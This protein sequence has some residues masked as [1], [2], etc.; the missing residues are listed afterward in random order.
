MIPPI[1]PIAIFLPRAKYGAMPS[2]T[3]IVI[4][5]GGF[6]GVYTALHLQHTWRR[7][8]AVQITLVSRDNFFVMTPLLF[9]A[10]SGILEP[11]HA[12]N[13]IRPMFDTVRF[14]EAEIES[15]DIDKK[16]VHV[17]L[18]GDQPSDIEYDHIVLALGGITNT[19]LVPGSESA[20][21]FKTLGDAIFLRNHC[22][23]RFERADAQL[24]PTKRKA[25]LTFVIIGAGFVGVELV[26][27]LTEFLFRV[28]RLYPNAKASDLR[29][30]LIEAG[31][32]IAPE[33]DDTLT[34]Y[35]AKVLTKRGVHI[36]TNTKIE[37]IES[38]KVYFPGGEIVETET[39]IIATGVIPSPLVSVLPLEKSKK[40]AI[41][42]EPTMRVKTHPEIWAIGDCASIPGPDGK[43]YPALA[44]HAIRE[45]KCLA[46]NIT[47]VI[48]TWPLKPFVYQTK[49]SLA[50]LGHYQG[51]GLVYKFRIK[52]LLAWWVWR[53]YYLFQMPRWERRLRVMI[54]WTVAL[55]FKNDVVQLDLTRG[56]HAPKRDEPVAVKT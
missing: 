53:S 2:P 18:E 3:R 43:P 40:G 50:A 27:E 38:Q 32:R 35:A 4:L 12:V 17:K 16:L 6:A 26:G 36:R 48:R 14:I 19:A 33:F 1:L 24:D 8:P 46:N 25:P 52:G 31:P 42:V 7:D 10:G 51:V 49:G 55:F 37:R 20:F 39:V 11:R 44:Q 29:F 9:E 22:I 23:Q 41:V 30:E 21:T 13:P 54:D 28:A 5:G 45:A 47:A 15:I 56:E 34:D